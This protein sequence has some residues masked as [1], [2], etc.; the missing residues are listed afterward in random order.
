M[1][2][3]ASDRL[4]L[5][6]LA[7][8]A[9]FL[10]LPAAS[11]AA[12]PASTPE[13]LTAFIAEMGWERRPGLAVGVYQTGRPVYLGA[14]GM[15]DLEQNRPV[16]PGTVFNAASVSKHFTAFA[17]L[18]LARDGKLTLD[19]DV[20]T[21]LPYVPDFGETI[22]VRHLIYH[23]S[24]LREIGNLFL[25]A[26]HSQE[27]Y[28]RQAHVINLVERQQALNF[29][30]G[31]DH[32]YSNTNYALLAEIVRAASGQSFRQF[33]EERI[34]RPLGMTQSF[35]RDDVHDLIPARASSYSCDEAN[36]WR[37]AIDSD[38]IVGSTNLFTTAEDLL[39]WAANLVEPKVGGPA[40]IEEFLRTG[41]ID[42]G[43]PIGYGFG[44]H[45]GASLGYETIGHGGATAGYRSEFTYFPEKELAVV[46]LQN[47]DR[48]VSKVLEEIVRIRL[49]PRETVSAVPDR[50]PFTREQ[51]DALTGDYLGAFGPMMSLS[52]SKEGLEV[53]AGGQSEAERLVT[54][55]DGT[56]DFGDQWRAWHN[57]YRPVRDDEGA[58]IAL[59]EN[60]GGG[61]RPLLYRR[62]TAIQAADAP[63]EDFAGEWRSSEL[64]TTYTLAVEDGRLAVH[65]LWLPEPIRLWPTVTDQFDSSSW[66]LRTLAFDR[67]AS[68]RPVTFRLHAGRVRNILF[69]RVER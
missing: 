60:K 66:W 40:L 42:D 57:F 1:R 5:F 2:W 65:A 11:R 52:V 50:A 34:F 29:V 13:T 58:V 62:V 59:H 47:S 68:G 12:A 23:T 45:P 18:L 32:L 44:L 15:A 6:S 46:F 17:V 16:T 49:E 9:G 48:D 26:G 22:T 64:D 31:T 56:F 67:D 37:N 20:R 36:G 54:R 24:G 39:K 8:L 35:I 69:E 55:V 3:G 53:H 33:V 7:L 21:Y 4:F 27:G 10:V 41:T 43:T 30:P 63:L 38:E 25:M 14:W 51:L 28:L 61:A 19:D